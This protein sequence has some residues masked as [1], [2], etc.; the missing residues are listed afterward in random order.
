MVFK[1]K[2]GMVAD[3]RA[4]TRTHPQLPV[5]CFQARAA[6]RATSSVAA[7]SL[8]SVSTDSHSAQCTDRQTHRLVL[9][10]SN[11]ICFLEAVSH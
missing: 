8:S 10:V 7:L 3:G 1:L 11:V 4:S 2:L 5:Q 6:L 9:H